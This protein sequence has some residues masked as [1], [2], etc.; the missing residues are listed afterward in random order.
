MKKN[1]KKLITLLFFC[2]VVTGLHAQLS[3]GAKTGLAVSDFSHANESSAKTGYKLGVSLEYMFSSRWGIQSGVYTTEIG[4]SN[5]CGYAP[6]VNVP[7]NYAGTVTLKLSPRYFEIP[8]SAVYKYP[9]D[10]NVRIGVNAGIYMAYGYSGGGSL[11]E[12]G[13]ESKHGL[14]VFEDNKMNGAYLDNYVLKA[15]NKIDAGLIGGLFLD[16]YHFNISANFNFGLENV[17]DRFPIMPESFK[18]FKNVQN[19]IFWIGLGYNFM[20]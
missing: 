14:N 10:E 2:A 3:V 5:S 19:R 1:A 16:V 6:L 9:V 13:L 18:G 15:A 11:R 12:E 17:Y 4:I 20:L 7:E 8:I